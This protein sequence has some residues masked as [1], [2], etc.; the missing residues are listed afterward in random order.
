MFFSCCVFTGCK[1]ESST[2]NAQTELLEEQNI[3]GDWV[4]NVDG[5]TANLINIFRS[6]GS[7]LG[8]YVET[9]N[10]IAGTWKISS[11][12]III[13]IP[14][15]EAYESEMDGYVPKQERE[16]IELTYK[17]IDEKTLYL[18]SEFIWAGI[19]IVNGIFKKF[20]D[21][22]WDEYYNTY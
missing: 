10:S 2:N 15:R 20:S 3:I 7:W 6:D 21:K 12:K 18:S 4:K 1:K 19:G 14:E 17:F 11:E 8:G 9:S 13:E 5:R 16:I 22:D